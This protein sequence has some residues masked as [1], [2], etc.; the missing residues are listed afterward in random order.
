[1]D[2]E[3]LSLKDI[4]LWTIE[5]VKCHDAHSERIK[6]DAQLNVCIAFAMALGYM[7]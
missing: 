1:M 7:E 2:A 3:N 5:M 4:R 6:R